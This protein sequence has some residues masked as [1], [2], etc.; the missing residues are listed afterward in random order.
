MINK[1]IKHVIYGS[2][3]EFL[4]MCTHAGVAYIPSKVSN[5]D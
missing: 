2:S 3:H 4:I 5:L 1:R